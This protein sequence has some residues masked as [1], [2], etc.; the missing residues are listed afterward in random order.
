M[1]D[2]KQI[3]K[4]EDAGFKRWT[5]NNMD[6][7]YIDTTKIGLEG[8]DWQGVRQSKA[9]TRRIYF[10]KVW[11]DVKDGSLHVKSDYIPSYPN[12]FSVEDAA[13]K[14]IGGIK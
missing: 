7:L 13:K 4:F 6:R 2:A 1:M 14:Y 12:P 3:K 10:S 11:I 9:D 8:C 5:K